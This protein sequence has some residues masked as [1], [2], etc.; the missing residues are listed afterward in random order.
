MSPFQNRSPK[1]S[2]LAS[3]NTIQVSERR[4]ASGSTTRARYCRCVF[5][6]GRCSKAV[7]MLDISKKLVAGRHHGVRAEVQESFDGIGT[8]FKN[9]GKDIVSGAVAGRGRRPERFSL[10]AD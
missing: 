9:R 8:L 4:S 6:D 5:P 1:P 3:S 2:R 10:P 7:V